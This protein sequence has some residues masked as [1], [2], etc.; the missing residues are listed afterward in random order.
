MLENRTKIYEIV[1]ASVLFCMPLILFFC[2]RNWRG[3]ISNY[4]YSEYAYIF[5]TLITIGG[6][7]FLTNYLLNKK[8]WYNLLIGLS[9]IGVS[10]TPHLDYAIAHY[11]FAA[12]FFLGSF[13]SILF[14]KEKTFRYV[15]L[16]T[17]LFA[18]IT[19]ICSL[20]FKYPSLLVAEWIG[21]LPI[22]L[23]FILNYLD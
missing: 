8:H 9:L 4:A 23:N 22:F 3:A 18:V 16:A 15:K 1:T 13:L 6:T 21:M 14:D 7:L 12:I 10:I 20:V 2:E 19:I 11:I 17:V 5:N